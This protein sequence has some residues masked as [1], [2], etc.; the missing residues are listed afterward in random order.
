MNFHLFHQVLKMINMTQIQRH[1]QDLQYV[2]FE[3]L[4]LLSCQKERLKQRLF[5]EKEGTC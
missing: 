4:S 2:S 3:K 1:C 5:K